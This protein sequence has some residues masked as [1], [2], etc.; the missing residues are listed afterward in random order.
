MASI[1]RFDL[2]RMIGEEEVRRDV[3]R[4]VRVVNDACL[5]MIHDYV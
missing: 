5:F 4:Y 3:D 2:V 1:L